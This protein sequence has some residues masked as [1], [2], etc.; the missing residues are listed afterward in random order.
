MRSLFLWLYLATIMAGEAPS[1]P[2]GQLAVGHVYQRNKVWF[3]HQQ[4]TA[5]SLAMALIWDT[6]PDPTM[7]A[8]YLLG[9]KDVLPW[10]T[11]VLVV[12]DCPTG[13]LTA[14]R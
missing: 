8:T 2:I 7:G 12:I 4:P 10:H 13:P 1:C 11:E 3:G 14:R 6:V 5:T 9:P